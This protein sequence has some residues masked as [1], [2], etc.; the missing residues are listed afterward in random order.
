MLLEYTID[1]IRQEKRQDEARRL[2]EVQQQRQKL[3]DYLAN[4]IKTQRLDEMLGVDAASIKINV[5]DNYDNCK[6]QAEVT[7]AFTYIH[8]DMNPTVN[9]QMIAYLN[10]EDYPRRWDAPIVSIYL[11]CGQAARH[12]Y[13]EQG[14]N[15]EAHAQANHRMIADAV[16]YLLGIN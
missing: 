4:L 5:R 1:Q 12:A 16:M 8:D 13:I 9:V 11:N 10:L 2:Q 3:V 7:G 14:H 6:T 15:T